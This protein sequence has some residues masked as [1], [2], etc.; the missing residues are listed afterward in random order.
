M[1]GLTDDEVLG[2]TNKDDEAEP[3]EAS[4]PYLQAVEIIKSEITS[5]K[6]SADRKRAFLWFDKIQKLIIPF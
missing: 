1:N 5:I 6:G 2:L 4:M 3:V